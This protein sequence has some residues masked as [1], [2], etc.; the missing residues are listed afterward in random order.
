MTAR[1]PLSST[2]TDV[3]LSVVVLAAQAMIATVTSIGDGAQLDA[4]GWALLTV[5]T[6]VL[7]VRRRHPGLVLAGV[8]VVSLPYHLL[9]YVHEA[10]VL[11]P[12]VALYTVASAGPRRRTLQ[13]GG[14][15]AVL[16]AAV[17]LLSGGSGGLDLISSVG[18][19]PMTMALGEAVRLQ[20][21]YVAAIVERAER[22]ERTR[23]QEAARQVAEERVRIARDLHD[24]LAH[25]ITLVGVQTTV[26]AHVLVEKPDH[27]DRSALAASLESISA[28]CRDART[29]LRATLSVL[30]AGETEPE[31]AV[32]GIAAVTD[33]VETVRATGLEVEL[34]FDVDASAVP[35]TVG[36]TTYRIVQEALTNVIKHADATRAHVSVA[37]SA[38]RL[39]LTVVD[40]GRGGEPSSD[41]HGILGMV[42]RARSVGGTLT[43]M[44]GPRGGFMV[45]AQLPLSGHALPETDV[46]P[47]R[48]AT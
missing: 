5:G 28:T 7:V 44:P 19:V 3:L 36:V 9:D 38:G 34:T 30:R 40:D 46:E 11:G 20:R 39:H 17:M 48:S 16:I 12:L 43:A 1:W 24:L 27:L 18:W 42:E 4:L 41:G 25:S 31:T 26:A 2:S 8:V 13:I 6:M 23:E 33:V 45:S 22:A 47:V 32:P 14:A 10:Y 21:A 29:E 15:L 37:G 35:S